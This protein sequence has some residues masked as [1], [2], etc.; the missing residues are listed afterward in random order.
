MGL[1][2][3]PYG[4][5]GLRDTMKLQVL[6]ALNRAEKWLNMQPAEGRG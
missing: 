1:H 5:G 4:N 2:P 6:R 3:A